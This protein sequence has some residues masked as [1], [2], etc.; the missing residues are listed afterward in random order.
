[1][2]VD[3]LNICNSARYKGSSN[4]NSYTLVKAIAEELRGL[5]KEYNCAILTGTQLNR[6]GVDNT[7]VSLKEISESSGLSHTVDMLFALM[8]TEELDSINQ[9]M[10]KQL[11][12]RFADMAK[13]LRFV[14]GVDRAKFRYYD[15]DQSADSVNDMAREAS[16]K[17]RDPMADADIEENS[18][19]G[20]NFGVSKRPKKTFSGIS[21]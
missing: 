6:D 17:D 16:R 5:A 19:Q 14:F 15:V 18:W 9:V 8:R 1:M 13:M 7:N 21:A 10:I 11:K 4:I 20:G 12:N 2:I 3:Y